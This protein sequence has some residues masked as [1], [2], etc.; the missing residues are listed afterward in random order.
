MPSAVI[1]ADNSKS[2]FSDLDNGHLSRFGRAAFQQFIQTISYERY[3]LNV[4]LSTYIIVIENIVQSPRGAA[5]TRIYLCLFF[6]YR[7]FPLSV[8]LCLIFFPRLQP[9]RKLRRKRI[10]EN[11]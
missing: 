2:R 11:S 3:A 4:N 6:P 7:F 8:F 1:N 9:I 10:E 5:A